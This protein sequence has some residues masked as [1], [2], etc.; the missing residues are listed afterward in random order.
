MTTDTDNL[1]SQSEKNIIFLEDNKHSVGN[2]GKCNDTPNLLLMKNV[3][4]M[5]TMRPEWQ[6][7][8]IT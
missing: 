2:T 6:S 1:V 4:N 3:S 8:S 7:A 5:M